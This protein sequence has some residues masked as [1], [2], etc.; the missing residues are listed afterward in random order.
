MPGACP[1][2]SVRA[3]VCPALGKWRPTRS[4]DQCPGPL[5]LDMI[6]LYG[7]LLCNIAASA[8]RPSVPRQVV[9]RGLRGKEQAIYVVEYPCTNDAGDVL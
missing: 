1:E 8:A 3:G 7:I 5:S 2:A 4:T 6:Q 9:M